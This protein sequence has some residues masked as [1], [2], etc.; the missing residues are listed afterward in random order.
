M[1]E[2]VS[3]DLPRNPPVWVTNSGS[4]IF[5]NDARI[6]KRDLRVRIGNEHYVHSIDRVLEPTVPNTATGGSDLNNP[7]AKKYLENASIYNIT[8]G[9]RIS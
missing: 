9:Y 3:T 5:L 2:F 8:G 4:E 6:L 7:D 1:D